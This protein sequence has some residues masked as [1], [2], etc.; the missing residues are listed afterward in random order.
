MLPDNVK[1]FEFD[2]RFTA[3]GNDFQLYDFN[4]ASEDDYLKEYQNKFDLLIVDPPFLSEECLEK[5]AIIVK[6]LKNENSLVVLNTGLVQKE[7]A[8]RF[9][10]LRETSFKPQHKNN[11]ANEFAS[12]A[13]FDMDKYM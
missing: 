4:R 12:F 3:F 2:E 10:N 1:I 5:T 6:R 13:N 11:L 8:A 7:H 9:L